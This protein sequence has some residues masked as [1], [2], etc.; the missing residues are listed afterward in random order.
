MTK[1]KPDFT[2]EWFPFATFDEHMADLIAFLLY[3]EAIT[4]EQAWT[5]MPESQRELWK[6]NL[7]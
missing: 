5:M 4:K 2:D 1:T 6:A 7:Q 3:D